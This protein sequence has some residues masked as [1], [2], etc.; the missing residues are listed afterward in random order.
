MQQPSDHDEWYKMRDR[1]YT[2]IEGT[3]ETMYTAEETMHSTYS[4]RVYIKPEDVIA[5]QEGKALIIAVNDGE[6]SLMI[7]SNPD[8]KEW[9]GIHVTMTEQLSDEHE[10]F[11]TDAAFIADWTAWAEAMERYVRFE[12]ETR[13][14]SDGT[15]YLQWPVRPRMIVRESEIKYPPMPF[16]E[17][18]AVLDSKDNE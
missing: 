14:F 7:H 6:Y 8:A 11:E 18:A 12:P 16:N 3:Q 5:L 9:G 1:D 17:G 15:S 4:F 2:V 13:Y 10:G